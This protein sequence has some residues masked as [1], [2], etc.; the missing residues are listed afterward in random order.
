MAE[1]TLADLLRGL[2]E[3]VRGAQVDIEAHSVDEYRRL[4]DGGQADAA[5]GAQ[6]QMIGLPLPR[7]DGSYAT[8]DIPIAALM[9]HYSVVLDEVRIRLSA[10]L[11][12]DEREGKIT[13][14]LA[15]PK[16][17]RDTE[18]S[19]A[20]VAEIELLLKRGDTPEG[21]ARTTKELLKAI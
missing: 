12:W 21:T 10:R 17:P 20:P 7:L 15:A 14:E 5:G 6:P 13:V 4:L 9:H 11:G 18:G 16:R 19:Q 1:I 8:R 3:A 2:G